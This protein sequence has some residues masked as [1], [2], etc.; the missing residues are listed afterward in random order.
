MQLR[1]ARRNHAGTLDTFVRRVTQSR[2]VWTISGAEGL[3][4]VP[5]PT[6]RGRQI[7]LMWST[8]EEAGPWM[9]R[10]TRPRL[11]PITLRNVF[12][13]V[14]PKLRSLNRLVGTDWVAADRFGPECEPVDIERCL[15]TEAAR[16]FARE[17]LRAGAVWVL[18]DEMGPAFATSRADRSALVLPCWSSR[19]GAEAHCSG[20]WS[21]MMISRIDLDRFTA[22]TLPWLVKLG[23]QVAP[24]HGLGAPI[25]QPA[26]ELA[27]GLRRTLRS[28][29]A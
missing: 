13:D 17:A 20:F 29:A 19:E 8:R 1:L 16:A 3:S 23:R 12:D 25:E 21:E 9:T 7:N 14:L 24:N 18:E 27:D 22:K 28:G 15:R 5:S 11:N 6:H 2:I 26:E 4:R 10:F